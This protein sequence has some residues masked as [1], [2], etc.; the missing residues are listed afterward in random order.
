VKPHRLALLAAAWLLVSCEMPGPLVRGMFTRTESRAAPTAA[1]CERCHQEVVRE[2]RSSLHASAWESPAF[3]RA[4]AGGRAAECTGCHAPAPVAE[5]RPVAMRELHVAEGVTCTS[6][7]LS[8]RPDAPPL[9]MRGPVS[10]TSPIEIHPIIERDPLYRSS[11]LC[12]TCH[13]GTLREWRA[14]AEPPGGETKATCQGCHMPAVER[15]VESVHDEHAYSALFVA[16]G[17]KAEL[18]RHTFAVPEI[19]PGDDVRLAV[20]PVQEGGRRALEVTVSN[21]LPHALPTGSFGR[22]EVRIAAR[23]AGGSHE[24]RRSRALGEAIPSGG[25]WRTRIALPA[26][27]DPAGVEVALERWDRQ[28]QA[29]QTLARAGAGS[30]APGA[31]GAGRKETDRL[32][33]AWW[34]RGVR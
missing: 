13:E 17:E 21:G 18:R 11:E 10:R 29:W 27:V 6:C 31:T 1:D 25:E 19:G 2:W 23:W 16:L 5:D 28:G 34:E 7:H 9:T 14:A 4:S 20:A 15:K 33:S 26:G 32:A 30:P 12:G 3:Q 24:A 8:P 22:R